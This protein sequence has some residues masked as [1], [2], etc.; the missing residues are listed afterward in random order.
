MEVSNIPRVPIR[1]NGL[2]CLIFNG[3]KVLT[4]CKVIILTLEIPNSSKIKDFINRLRISGGF[5]K[6]KDN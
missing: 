2:I 5:E 3:F 1:K 6:T 4:P